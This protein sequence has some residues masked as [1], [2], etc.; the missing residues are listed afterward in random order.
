VREAVPVTGAKSV[1]DNVAVTVTAP[2]V[3]ALQVATPYESPGV[4]P[5]VVFTGSETDHVTVV[6]LLCA[7]AQLGVVEPAKASNCCVFPGAA[8]L[9]FT[10]E[11]FGETFSDRILQPELVL[12]PHPARTIDSKMQTAKRTLRPLQN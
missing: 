3:A 11:A 10:A 1:W 7:T 2:D 5:I 12:P 9:W 4:V 8:A 6:K